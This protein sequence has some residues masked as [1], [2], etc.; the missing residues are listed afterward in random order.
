MNLGSGVGLAFTKRL[1]ELHHGDITAES[2]KEEGSIFTVTIPISDEVYKND[3][4]VEKL[5][6]TTY[7]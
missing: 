4:H 5:L 2:T 3:L 7:L 1:V 6:R